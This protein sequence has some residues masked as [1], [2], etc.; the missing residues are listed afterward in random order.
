MLSG[1]AFYVQPSTFRVFNIHPHSAFSF[2][3]FSL[4]LPVFYLA[5]FDVPSHHHFLYSGLKANL[6]Y[7]VILL[8]VPFSLWHSSASYKML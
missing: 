5:S 6:R 4:L 7:R 3:T 2:S 8:C 1:P